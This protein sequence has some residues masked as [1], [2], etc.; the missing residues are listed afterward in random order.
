LSAA[1]KR[2]RRGLVVGKFCPLHRGHMLVID[3]ALAAC[4]DVMVISYTNPEFAGCGPARRAAWLAA[5]YPQV[6]ALVL[7]DPAT[8]PGND[9]P[10]AVQR[11]FCARLC[12][13]VPGVTVDAVFTSETYGDGFALALAASFGTPVAHVN[14]DQ[15][16]VA[17]PISGTAL[18]ADPHGNRRYLHPRVYA[19]F[20]QRACILGGESS[21][22]TTLARALAAHLGT[23]WAPEYGRELWERQAGVLA[24][25]DMV[26]IGAAQ[27]ARE[28]ALAEE[29]HR[30]LVCDTSP[31]TTQFYSQAMFDAVDP[32][33]AA[34]AH[35]PY[36]VTF[37][38]APDFDFVQDGTR[39]DAAFRQ[40][41]H[42]WYCAELD[43]RG[44]AYTLLAGPLDA[45]V[46]QAA[47]VLNMHR[48]GVGARI[49]GVNSK[50]DE[51]G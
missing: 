17:V 46:A 11:A 3:T 14:V 20:V 9:A 36:A 15:A 5:L 22:K 8:I 50:Q 28:E 51:G 26:H 25:A 7:G 37:V 40:R 29:A 10:D 27:L 33:L 6:R 13:A 44:I 31:L 23:A 32:A 24:Y 16:R 21:G 1:V 39:V 35:Q 19:D 49:D 41:Q 30:W 34:M 48:D 45:R 12:S 18:R 4:D 47:R 43:R 2:Y 42:A 38:C